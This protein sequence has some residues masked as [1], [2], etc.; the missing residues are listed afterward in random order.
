[1]TAS[2]RARLPEPRG[3]LSAAVVGTLC[4]AQPASTLPGPEVVAADP[5][6]SDVAMA[7]HACYELHYGGFDDVDD[8]WEWDPELL[9]FRA[10]LEQVFLVGL[11]S[12][13][14]GGRDV[15]SA[16]D[17]LLVE[18]VPGT[19][20][21]HHL[22]D[23]APWWQL[24][25]YV[26]QRSIYH[27]KEADPQAWVI[28]RVQGRAKAGLVTVEFD[29]YGGGRAERMHSH[30]FA[31]MM[32]GMGLSTAYLGYQDAVPAPAI[33]IVNLMSMFGLHR[34]W[35]G[36]MVGQFTF[37]EVTSSPGAQ[38]MVQAL[39][40]LAVTPATTRF[41]DEHVEADAV[42]E[43]LLRHEVVGDLLTREPDLAPDVVFGLQ[44]IELLEDQMADQC[45]SAWKRGESSLRSPLPEPH[46]SG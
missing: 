6:G 44:S 7:L 13:V 18:Y 3:P 31:E 39:E 16:V 15:E 5:F 36:A 20:L 32:Q 45:M 30:L 17:R 38:R 24:R 41:Y 22:R 21:S 9:R 40:R 19:G 10:A 25:E 8:A 1:V 12:S 33:A 14:A 46:H 23:K 43:Q 37:V 29:E 2:P 35:R 34:R 27:L 26:A 4:G 42:H 11:W 28:P